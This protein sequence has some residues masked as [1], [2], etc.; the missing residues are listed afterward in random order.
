MRCEKPLRCKEPLQ[1]LRCG[2]CGAAAALAELTTAEANAVYDCLKGEMKSAYA[3][4]GNKYAKIFLNWKNYAKQPYISGTH[5]QRY[6]LNYANEKASNYGKYE[7]AGKM[8]PGAVTAKNSFTV[9]SK[10]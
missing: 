10:G 8:T 6:V 5:G 9:D 3:K 7:N 1:S 2:P 4:S